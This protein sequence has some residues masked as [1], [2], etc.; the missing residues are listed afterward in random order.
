MNEHSLLLPSV[1]RTTTM[2]HVVT[3][4]VRQ[5]WATVVSPSSLPWNHEPLSL[6]NW[7]L[8]LFN[9][10]QTIVFRRVTKRDLSWAPPSTALTRI[11]SFGSALV[12]ICN[13]KDTK[14][15]LI[16]LISVQQTSRTEDLQIF[17]AVGWATGYI[18][19]TLLRNTKCGELKLPLCIWK[20]LLST[21][22]RNILKIASR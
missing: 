16:L 1:S 6:Q 20:F 13:P 22:W 7:C 10:T 17:N 4:A 3:P 12:W 14:T 19:K 11:C 21:E 8:I 9:N 15:S 18:F 5:L 2:N